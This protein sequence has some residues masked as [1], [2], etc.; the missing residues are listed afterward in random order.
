MKLFLW[1]S[2]VSNGV[3]FIEL[4]AENDKKVHTH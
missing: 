2:E 4:E 1:C 3:G